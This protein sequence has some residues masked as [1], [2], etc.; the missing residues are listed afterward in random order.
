MNDY[1]NIQALDMI[2]LLGFIAQIN[3]IQKD[4]EYHEYIEKFFKQLFEEIQKLYKA[5][6]KNIKIIRKGWG[7]I[8]DAINK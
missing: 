7:E 2:N 8:K 1:N 5:K 3:N 4:G 6:W